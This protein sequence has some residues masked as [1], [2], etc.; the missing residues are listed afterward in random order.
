[1]AWLVHVAIGLAVAIG[2]FFLLRWDAHRRPYASCLACR[3]NPRRNP[4]STGRAWGRCPVCKGSAERR[5]LI[6]VL[7]RVKTAAK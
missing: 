2:L 6:A 5:R 4:G 1:M 3:K 7:F